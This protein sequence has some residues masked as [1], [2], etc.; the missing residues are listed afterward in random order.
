MK[1]ECFGIQ[2]APGGNILPVMKGWKDF[3]G[4]EG[5]IRRARLYDLTF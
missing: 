2:L 4:V 1:L 5:A 3:A